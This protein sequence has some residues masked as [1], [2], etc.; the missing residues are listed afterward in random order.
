[1]EQLHL[2]QLLSFYNKH[3]EISKNLSSFLYDFFKRPEHQWIITDKNILKSI[4]HFFHLFK[5]DHLHFFKKNPFTLLKSN[6][7][8]SCTVSGD[9]SEHIILIFPELINILKTDHYLKGLA[10]LGHEMGHLFFN[11]NLKLKIQESSDL[12]QIQADSFCQTLGLGQYLISILEEIQTQ[13]AKIRIHHL[14]L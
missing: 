3:S 12:I 7:L 4:L 9:E 1:M 8:Y 13:E 6:G 10:I 5:Q 14:N 11:H 2:D